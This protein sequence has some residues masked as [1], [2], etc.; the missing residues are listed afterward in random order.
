MVSLGLLLTACWVT[1]AEI[2]DKIAGDADTDVDSD[3]DGDADVDGDVVV[4]PAD[5]TDAGGTEVDVTVDPLDGEPSV[6]FAGE[7]GTVTGVD[8]NVIHVVTPAGTAGPVDVVVRSDAGNVRGTGAFRYWPD[9][10]GRAGALGE[11][12]W[13]HYQGTYWQNTTDLDYGNASIAF[14]EPADVVY[15]DLWAPFID[16]CETHPSATSNPSVVPIDASDGTAALHT[17]A[18]DLELGWSNDDAA[19]VDDL[20]TGDWRSN[21]DWSFRMSGSAALPDLAIDR[22][23]HTPDNVQIDTPY[24]DGSSVSLVTQDN[25]TLEWSQPYTGDY[26]VVMLIR[27]DYFTQDPAEY[28][29]CM[30]EDDGYFVV[31]TWAWDDWQ[32]GSQVTIVLGRVQTSTATLPYND[33]RVEV[34]GVRFAV[35]AVFTL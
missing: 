24:V 4:V 1:P 7:P 23:L 27:Y 20:H 33:A 6:E 35:G 32:S 8:G 5:G 11:L 30:L 14:I 25:F 13:R 26:V 29:K 17:G 2:N 12:S 28:V 15:G 3:S 16:Y 10:T 22:F 18:L 19:F 31:P 21:A 9:G 34:A